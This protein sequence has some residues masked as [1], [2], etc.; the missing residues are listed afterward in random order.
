M[1]TIRCAL[2]YAGI[3]IHLVIW[4]LGMLKSQ[5]VTATHGNHSVTVQLTRGTPQ[6]GVHSQLLFNLVM[7][8]LLNKLNDV[9]GV[10]AQA[11]ADDVLD[12][13]WNRLF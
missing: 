7:N 2:L 6:G 1:A 9:P 3:E 5:R 4:I 12:G 11:Y 13:Y 8:E 10:Y